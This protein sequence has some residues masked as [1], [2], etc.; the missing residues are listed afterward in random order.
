MSEARGRPV[1]R[2]VARSDPAF[3][4]AWSASFRR[5]GATELAAWLDFALACADAADAVALR[6]FREAVEIRR[7]P[8]R[9]YVTEADT[10][11]ER[12]LRERIADAYPGHAIV[13]EEEGDDGAAAAVRWYLDPIDG[14]HNFM[15]G[16]PLFGILLALEVDGELQLG[17]VSA[18]GLG[19]RW[20]AARGLG[21]WAV[22]RFG[23]RRPR[24]RRIGV[25]GVD[26]LEGAQLL[27]RSLTDIEAAGVGPGF[28]DLLGRAWRSRGFG[29]FWGYALVA[30]GAA[31]AMVEA[32][33]SPWDL[34][35]PTILVEE[36][37]GRI[38]DF[39]GRR[40]I[41]GRS[42]LASNGRLHEELLRRL[43]GG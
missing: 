43:S 18:P 15:R 38:T 13:G 37:G 30:E 7:K 26:R 29:D 42:A 9:T 27:Y 41:H 35:A 1:P 12:L 28:R 36:A 24:P 39:A 25:S 3:G 32:D 17:V 4:P 40:T 2:S 34:A 16:I 19:S 11:I 8:D 10:A 14:T 33:L 23:R 5:A 20:Y 6:F 22:H 21:A 31:E